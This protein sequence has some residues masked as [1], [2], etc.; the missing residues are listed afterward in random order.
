MV[1]A[2]VIELSDVCDEVRRFSTRWE[3]DVCRG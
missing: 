1:C 2:Y 3:V